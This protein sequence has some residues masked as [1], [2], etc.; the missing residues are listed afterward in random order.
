M[1]KIVSIFCILLLLVA[2]SNV[3][4]NI[5]FCGDSISS[6]SFFGQSKTCGAS[7]DSKT[8]IHEKSCCKNFSAVISTDDTTTSIFSFNLGQQI[9]AIVPIECAVKCEYI[10][11]TEL[12]K[13]SDA[14]NAP[15]NIS[16][17]PFY[18]LYNSL[19]I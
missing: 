7:C 11:Y 12:L 9:V 4:V 18:I 14:C 1:K 13:S 17:Q 6:V 15:P 5:H 3:A 8:G 19:I 2:T 10:H 16:D